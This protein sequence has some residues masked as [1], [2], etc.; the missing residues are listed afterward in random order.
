MKNMQAFE[1]IVLRL[2]DAQKIRLLTEL[3]GLSPSELRSFGL[4]DDSFLQLNF[5]DGD[6]ASPSVLARSFDTDLIRKL[7]ASRVSG[8]CHVELPS[9]KG[10]IGRVNDSISED[11]F[12]SG[13]IAGAYLDGARAVGA[14]VYFDGCSFG[15][16]NEYTPYWSSDEPSK[17][18]IEE[19]LLSPFAKLISECTAVTADSDIR[20]KGAVT[21]RRTA[22]PDETVLAISRGDI[23]ISASSAALQKALFNY[24]EL[25]EKLAEGKLMPSELEDALSCGDAISDESINNAVTRVIALLAKVRETTKVAVVDSPDALKDSA[26]DASCALLSNRDRTLPLARSEKLC[27]LGGLA[28]LSGNTRE[29]LD[30]LSDRFGHKIVGLADGYAIGHERCDELLRPACELAAASDTVIVLLGTDGTNRVDTLPPSQLALCRAL[31]RL[32]KRLIL[33][34][35]CEHAVDLGFTKKMENSPSAI[36]LAPL[37][38]KNSLL[39]VLEMLFGQRSPKGRSTETFAD[40]KLAETARRGVKTGPF[41]GYRFYDT[42]DHGTIFPFGHGLSYTKFQ[43]SQPLMAGGNIEFTVKNT[44]RHSGVEI[45]QLYVGIESSAVLRPK[46]ELIGFCKLDLEPGESRIVKLQVSLP[47]VDGLTES[48]EYTLYIGASVSDI[49]LTHRFS[50]SGDA[51]PTDGESLCD[52]LPTHTNINKYNYKLEAEHKNMKPTVRS[53]ILGAAMLLLSAGVKIY[54]ILTLQNSLFLNIVSI[55]L[56]IGAVVFFVLEILDRKKQIKVEQKEIDSANQALFADADRIPIVNAEN[57]FTDTQIKKYSPVSAKAKS[58]IRH[59]DHYADVDPGLDLGTLSAELSAFAGEC[60]LILSKR[61]A[62]EI[63]AALASSRIIILKNTSREIFASLSYVLGNYLTTPSGIDTM[64][65]SYVSEADL[66][67]GPEGATALQGVIRS[68]SADPRNLHPAFFDE[69]TLS[70]LNDAF[71]PIAGYARSPFDLHTIRMPSGALTLTNNL[72]FIMSLRAGEKLSELPEHI[73]QT[74]AVITVSAKLAEKTD[75]PPAPRHTFSFGQLMYLTDKAI[76]ELSLKED[77]WKRLDQLEAFAA[78][79]S[80]YSLGNKRVIGFE[81][82][83][84]VLLSADPEAADSLDRALAA[85]IVPSFIAALDGKLPRDEVGLAAKLDE[86]FGEFGTSACRRMISDKN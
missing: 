83:L 24:R 68:A 11:P 31:H 23:C 36:L 32:K 58:E 72:W 47:A 22:S 51:V 9:A 19:Q 84:S 60:G 6:F 52:Y 66:L 78:R 59:Y 61:S 42:I 79:Y 37:G 30:E 45:A 4:A 15:S 81:N 46:K 40:R 62:A 25:K 71:S 75:A 50:H 39:M 44:G 16:E 38:V 12:L 80:D 10:A 26:F 28:A 17:R 70:E 74:A 85:K 54:D 56:M 65:R 73:S 64:S 48:G 29:E 8:T 20:P 55:A 41:V 14:S 43:Y 86:L 1:D 13:S 76:G 82:Q 35:S 77:I 18:L 33:V 53:L 34:I 27:I 5:A 63:F 21:L 2:S 3:G 7:T 49:R 69:V 57:L 67:V